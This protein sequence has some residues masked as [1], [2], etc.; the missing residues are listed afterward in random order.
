MSRDKSSDNL[1]TQTSRIPSRR[2][3]PQIP[4]H[5]IGF[6]NSLSQ[7]RGLEH[8][9]IESINLVSIFRCS[10]PPRNLVYGRRVDPSPLDFSLSS[11]RHSH[12]PITLANLSSINLV[13]IFRCSSPPYNPV[14]VRCVDPS[15]LAFI[16]PSH[17]HSCIRLLF[18][19]RFISS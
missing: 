18:T 6:H 12:S 19:S 3:R 8:L 4:S 10:S 5:S 17:R 16:L 13:S 14:Y 1:Q 11:H 2:D 9:K 7:P 15:D